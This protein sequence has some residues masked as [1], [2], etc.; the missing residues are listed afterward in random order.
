MFGTASRGRQGSWLAGLVGVTAGAALGCSAPDEAA[1][2]PSPTLQAS[3]EEPRWNVVLLIADD[4]NASLGCYGDTQAR[5]PRIDGL[6][7][8]GLRFSRAYCAYPL[9]NPSRSSLLTGLFPDS[10]APNGDVVSL[11][12]HRPDVV[13]LPQLFRRNGYYTAGI[14]KVFHDAV[15]TDNRGEWEYS[16]DYAN[17]SLGNKGQG[18]DLTPSRLFSPCRWLAADGTDEDQ[19]DGQIARG[20][21]EV[22]ERRPTDR[23]FFL[24]VGFHKPH[25]PFAAPRAYFDQFPPGQLRLRARYDGDRDDVPRPALPDPYPFSDDEARQLLRGYY[26]ATTFMD[27]QVGRV[28]DALDR[29]GLTSTTIVVLLGDNGHHLGEFDHWSK[30]TLFEPSTHVPLIIAGPGIPGGRVCARTVD[31]TGLYATLADVCRLS[32]VNAVDGAS[33]TALLADPDASWDAA[34]SECRPRLAL[35]HSVH[36]ERWRYTEWADGARGVELYDLERD[37]GEHV[38]LSSKPELA[39]TV[40]ELRALLRQRWPMQTP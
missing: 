4:L 7:A 14:S 5:T 2:S 3:R 17:T 38:N 12:T 35:G 6:A 32:L 15:G 23:P 30:A 36:T 11:R 20:A 28:L 37:P 1:V 25:E 26:A 29:L 18:R 8:R 31:L 27:A 10:I 13:S 24:G 21:I 34:Y 16:V 22:L 9:C 39:A 33:L 40:S 19:R